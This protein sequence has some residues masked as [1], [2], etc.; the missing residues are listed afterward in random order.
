MS[1]EQSVTILFK[2]GR[3]PSWYQLPTEQKT[4]FEQEH[5]DLMLSNAK[6]HHLHRIE[7]YRLITPQGGWERFWVIEFPTL[8]GAEAWIE[9]EMAPPYG[10]Y[11]LFDYQLARQVKLTNDVAWLPSTK[12]KPA[13]L[14]SD[15]HQ[16]PDLS[17]DQNSVV[18]MMS[19]WDKRGFGLA[20][21]ET[22]TLPSRA[23]AQGVSWLESYQ[24]ISP[25][26]D[27]DRVWLVELPDLASAEAWVESE[28]A[29]GR[30]DM[31][32]RHFQL[33]RKWAPSYFVNWI[34]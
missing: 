4:S 8:S 11:G 7:G 10:R 32:E 28:A 16:I 14:Q 6:R 33:T 1:D 25:R 17:A 24:L 12:P 26:A 34:S 27:W 19:E 18:A 30:E 3:L 20:A 2:G 15:A 5:V 29:A 21:S 9:A 13:A 22:P 23:Q 31:T